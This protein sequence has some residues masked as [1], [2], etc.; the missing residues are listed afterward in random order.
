MPEITY[1]EKLVLI[2]AQFYTFWMLR[3]EFH[4][5]KSSKI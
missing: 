5:F 4:K 3:T 2:N 1:Y